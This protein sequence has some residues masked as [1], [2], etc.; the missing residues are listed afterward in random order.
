MENLKML[1]DPLNLKQEVFSVKIFVINLGSWR[2]L[3]EKSYLPRG[4]IS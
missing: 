3:W 4:T 1:D 2:L